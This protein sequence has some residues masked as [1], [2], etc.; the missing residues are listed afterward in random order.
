MSELDGAYNS[1]E[2]TATIAISISIPISIVSVCRYVVRRERFHFRNT[3]RHWS[4]LCAAAATTE[5][6]PSSRIQ[7]LI[8]PMRALYMHYISLTQ[9]D[10][11]LSNVTH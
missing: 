8:S 7:H 2:H 3:E 1:F 10:E 6:G 5:H 9:C 4:I 11:Y